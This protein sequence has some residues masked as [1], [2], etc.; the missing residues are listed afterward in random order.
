MLVSASAVG[1]AVVELSGDAL[2][3]GAADGEP[4][5]G[6]PVA[7]GRPPGVAVSPGDGAG[8]GVPMGRT[9]STPVT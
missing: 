1:E 8:A 6:D 3:V 2:Y 9:R 5:V 7:D 4:G